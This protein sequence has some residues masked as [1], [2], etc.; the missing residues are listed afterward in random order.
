MHGSWLGCQKQLFIA[1]FYIFLSMVRVARMPKQLFLTY[2]LSRVVVVFAL[3]IST[4]WFV[5]SSMLGKTI[6]SMPNCIFDR[7]FFRFHGLC[8]TKTY[9]DNRALENIS[10]PVVTI[11]TF[12]AN[13]S[14]CYITVQLIQLHNRAHVA[15]LKGDAWKVDS[16]ML[17]ALTHNYVVFRL[18]DI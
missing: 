10:S 17:L 16:Y 5:R 7:S 11:S 1:L 18:V 8:I 15:K 12:G 6:M 2:D 4:M 13:S 3:N 14:N 9:Y